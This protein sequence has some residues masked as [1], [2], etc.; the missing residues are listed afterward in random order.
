MP[1][2]L[3]ACVLRQASAPPPIGSNAVAV[4]GLPP[5]DSTVCAPAPPKSTAPGCTAA[6][7]AARNGPPAGAAFGQVWVNA[8]TLPG[9]GGEPAPRRWASKNALPWSLSALS[10]STLLE[11]RAWP[12]SANC[13]AT[14]AFAFA[15]RRAL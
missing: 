6:Q 3:A 7:L 11:P 2:S 15:A 14:G 12:R 1:G 10:A 4:S 9:A 5:L 13:R 8:V